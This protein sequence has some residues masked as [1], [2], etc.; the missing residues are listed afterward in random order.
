MFTGFSKKG[1]DFLK[2]LRKNN[3]KEWFE[4]HKHIYT[5]HIQALVPTIQAG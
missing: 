2:A 3:T 4:A 1:L 5:E